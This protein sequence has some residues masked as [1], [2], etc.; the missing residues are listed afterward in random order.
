MGK[1]RYRRNEED[2]KIFKKTDEYLKGFTNQFANNCMIIED[3]DIK[4][5]YWYHKITEPGYIEPFTPGQKEYYPITL[6]K[7]DEANKQ[8]SFCGQKRNITYISNKVQFRDFT[9]PEN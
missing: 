5:I 1:S 3:K 2:S 8:I 6:V 9:T 7:I 4:R